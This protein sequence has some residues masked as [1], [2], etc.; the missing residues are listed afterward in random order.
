MIINPRGVK[1]VRH[2]WLRNI[3]DKVFEF[4][5]IEYPTAIRY[6]VTWIKT[7]GPSEVI[8]DFFLPKKRSN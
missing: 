6:R 5:M 1:L 8:H 7:L 3:N 4:N 2:T